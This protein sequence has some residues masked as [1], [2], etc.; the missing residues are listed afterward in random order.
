MYLPFTLYSQLELT[1]HL[2]SPTTDLLLITYLNQTHKSHRRLQ[3]IRAR[4]SLQPTNQ[5][6]VTIQ[7]YIAH[8]PNNQLLPQCLICTSQGSGSP[9]IKLIISFRNLNREPTH[10]HWIS[11]PRSSVII[12]KNDYASYTCCVCLNCCI[13]YVQSRYKITGLYLFKSSLLIR[14]GFIFDMLFRL[15]RATPYTAV[16]AVAAV[17]LQFIVSIVLLLHITLADAV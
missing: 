15:L 5:L 12:G 8:V 3:P 2:T 17:C 1:N 4:S 11:W 13:K 9:T 16:S 7:V 14:C 6:S 10:C